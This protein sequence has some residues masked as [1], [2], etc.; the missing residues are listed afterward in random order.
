MR[1]LFPLLAALL[2]LTCA[3]SAR[4][5]LAGARQALAKSRYGDAIAA[6]E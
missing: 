6:A 4:D 5:S 2:L 1:P 3:E